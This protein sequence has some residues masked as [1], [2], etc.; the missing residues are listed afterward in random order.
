MNP[1]DGF[2]AETPFRFCPA[3]GSP[4]GPPRPSGGATCPVCGRSFYRNP[5]PAVGAAI[6]SGG[7]ALVTV[8]A[9]EPYRGKIDVPGGFVELGEHPVDAL[10]REVREELG[11][12]A[13]VLW[14][15]VMFAPHR[16]GDDGVH[17]LAIGFRTEIVSGEPSPSDDVAEVLWTSLTDL[18]ALDFAWEHDREFIRNA[19]RQ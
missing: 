13:R 4:L 2:T 11:V 17:A 12:E 18:D 15:P 10:R 8:R 9:R 3:D 1:A 14:P 7:K 16:Y 5:A 19:L 6:L